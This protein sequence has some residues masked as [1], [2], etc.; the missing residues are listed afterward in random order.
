VYFVLCIVYRVRE[1][2]AIWH[3]FIAIYV[4]TIDDRR[5]LAKPVSEVRTREVIVIQP[6]AQ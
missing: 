4:S 1:S 6:Q 3:I 2:R 5:Q